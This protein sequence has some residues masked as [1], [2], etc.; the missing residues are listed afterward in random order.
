M[1][2]YTHTHR[3][4]YAL[5]IHIFLYTSLYIH[6]NT[7]MHTHVCMQI[8]VH[9][10]TSHVEFSNFILQLPA[11]PALSQCR[12]LQTLHISSPGMFSH[13]W[14]W[15][16]RLSLDIWLLTGSR[17]KRG[18]CWWDSSSRL[19][20]PQRS[21]DSLWSWLPNTMGVKQKSQLY[22]VLASRSTAEKREISIELLS[23]VLFLF[24]EAFPDG[25]SY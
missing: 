8:H 22:R 12:G 1:H 25:R 3:D 20:V 15:K 21:G 2:I 4:T 5:H 13:F 17:K 23:T 10:H 24:L 7:N 16:G 18:G 9:T 14:V 11:I 6:I 19:E